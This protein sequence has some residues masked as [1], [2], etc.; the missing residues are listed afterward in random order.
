M[1]GPWLIAFVVQWLLTIFLFLLVFGILRYLAS[2]KERWDSA[3]PAVTSYELGQRIVDVEL[4]DIKSMPFHLL[5][6]THRLNG[7]ILLFV[8]SGCGSCTTLLQQIAEIFNR[9]EA[10][11][12][13]TLIIIVAG[14][15][16][17]IQH[18][19]ETYPSLESNQVFFLSDE[20][21]VASSQF[22][23]LTMPT[24]LVLNKEG[25]IVDQTF[26]PHVTNWIY[27]ATNIQP[28]KEPLT[29]GQVAIFAPLNYKRN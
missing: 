6:L 1:S 16:K 7:A 15:P 8:S 12:E 21:S 23:I 10:S 28:P 29:T 25:G 24:A 13:R 3:V 22:G 14:S 17:N 5:D 18:F 4:N 11:L 9:S 2:V 26:N 27:R 20:R 19:L